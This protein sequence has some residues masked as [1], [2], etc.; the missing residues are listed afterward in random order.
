VAEA[1]ITPQH[2]LDILGRELRYPEVPAHVGER[3]TDIHENGDQE[4]QGQ[5]YGGGP[6]EQGPIDGATCGGSTHD[7]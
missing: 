4:E 5:E 2:A 6:Q 1:P 7:A 3:D